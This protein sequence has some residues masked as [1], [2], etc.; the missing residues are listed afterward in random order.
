MRRIQSNR[1]KLAT[2]GAKGAKGVDQLTSQIE[3]VRYSATRPGED[4]RA[5]MARGRVCA[6]G[7]LQDERLSELLLKRDDFV[8]YCI[9]QELSFFN[10]YKGFVSNAMKDFVRTGISVAEKVRRGVGREVIGQS[11]ASRVA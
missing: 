3:Q 9:L 10:H 7:R 2:M 8:T 1:S 4:K 6:R 11:R 5:L